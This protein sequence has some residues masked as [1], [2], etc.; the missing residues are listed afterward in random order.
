MA[1]LLLLLIAASLIP[2]SI[3]LFHAGPLSDRY[4]KAVSAALLSASLQAVFV[5]AVARNALT[6]GYS[7]RFA[8]VGIPACI[9]AIFLAKRGYG[10][11]RSGATLSPSIGL[12]I[13]AVLV[14]LH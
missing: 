12:I 6:L 9:L 8:S 10:D 3:P 14:T 2:A 4:W 11:W 5:I 13:W 1:Q 7:I